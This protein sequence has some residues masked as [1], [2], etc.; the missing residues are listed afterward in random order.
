MTA[1]HE[2]EL[3]LSVPDGDRLQ[4]VS[5][6]AVWKGLTLRFQSNTRLTD[7]YWDTPDYALTR[8]GWAIRLRVAGK[9]ASL[10]AKSLHATDSAGVNLRQEQH[11][12]AR[13]NFSGILATLEVGPVSLLISQTL[14]KPLLDIELTALFAATRMRRTY[15]ILANPLAY[16]MLDT[17]AIHRAG[18]ASP[19]L[20]AELARFYRLEL[21]GDPAAREQLLGWARG[22][23]AEIGA[24]IT[25]VSKFE[26]AW[27]ALQLPEE[28]LALAHAAA[29]RHPLPEPPPAPAEPPA[30][31]EISKPKRTQAPSPSAPVSEPLAT[32]AAKTDAK[33]A[34]TP[35]ID[36]DTDNRADDDADEKTAN[37]ADDTPSA[38]APL[39][40]SA[41][42]AVAAAMREFDAA[43]RKQNAG[44]S[45]APRGKRVR[46]PAAPTEPTQTPP[47]SDAP[48]ATETVAELA[49]QS[50][51]LRSSSSGKAPPPP[52][53][54][55]SRILADDPPVIAHA[56]LGRSLVVTAEPI[57]KVLDDACHDPLTGDLKPLEDW[58]VEF[59]EACLR[60]DP[61]AD[62]DFVSQLGRLVRHSPEPDTRADAIMRHA[63]ALFD[64]T[65]SIHKLEPRFRPLLMTIAHLAGADLP[66]FGKGAQRWLALRDRLIYHGLPDYD[67]RL[68]WML[69]LAL[70]GQNRDHRDT[71]APAW[72][73]L[74][75]EDR[76]D[77]LRL[78]ALLKF[79]RDFAK[80]ARGNWVP[81]HLDLR[82]GHPVL[83]IEAVESNRGLPMKSAGKYWRRTFGEPLPLRRRAKNDHP[84]PAQPRIKLRPL[85]RKQRIDMFCGQNTGS[86]IAEVL[87]AQEAVFAKQDRLLRDCRNAEPTRQLEQFLQDPLIEIVHDYRVA[88]RR[89]RS[90]C[91]LFEMPLGRKSVLQMIAPMQA[92]TEPTAA[93]RT[94]DVLIQFL[95]NDTQAGCFRVTGGGEPD[96]LIRWLLERRAE[97]LP[98]FWQQLDSSQIAASRDRMYAQLR[99]DRWCW[100]DR[101][102]PARLRLAGDEADF[103]PA[104][105][106]A[107]GRSRRAQQTPI[108][109]F[110]AQA[111]MHSLA[112]ARVLY[113]ATRPD[114]LHCPIGDL[115][116]VRIAL[117]KLRYAFDLFA[118]LMG[119]PTNEAIVTSK[120]LQDQ[121]GDINDSEANCQT[122][123]RML[124]TEP[125]PNADAAPPRGFLGVRAAAEIWL[126]YSHKRVYEIR[127]RLMETWPRL[128]S[129][130]VVEQLLADWWR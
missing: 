15:K 4:L 85:D 2:C 89:L 41:A 126:A 14:N 114:P 48:P 88:L 92:L 38:T 110:A 106:G 112:E 31:P 118:P 103:P 79:A 77:A 96:F 36:D 98:R 82:H 83:T 30:A 95:H 65:T 119:D 128:F 81:A 94:V 29:E 84:A 53:A 16:L 56:D 37:E 51:P 105:Q 18:E 28:L 24:E 100:T 72:R 26:L 47:T 22:L 74:P 33:S 19:Q 13:V 78:S 23:C 69:G 117:K 63:A 107:V 54:N 91:R 42:A 76:Q 122:L 3:I 120:K 57:D 12:R 7:I 44:D 129:P 21:E 59:R 102:G 39:T 9:E 20:G 115:H 130:A 49:D 8:A 66:A 58:P 101:F 127:L 109:T 40:G 43:A 52:R 121:L 90:Y 35:D 80:K 75:Y 60:R 87:A 46:P 113:Q 50:I 34:E 111:L 27:Q 25:P 116:A 11:Q 71:R 68:C 5:A 125:P 61:P 108:D 86:A 97:Y 17:G 93:L 10:Q 123:E 64:V 62:P 124:A 70:A 6:A 104:R 32:T 45:R 55:E 99:P 1:L 73:R 67:G